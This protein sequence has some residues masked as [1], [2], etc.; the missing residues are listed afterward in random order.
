MGSE[1]RGW[2]VT[3]IA[4]GA[5]EVYEA[6]QWHFGLMQLWHK[7][8]LARRSVRDS[9]RQRAEWRIYVAGVNWRTCGC[10]SGV[11]FR[12]R[13]RRTFRDRCVLTLTPNITRYAVAKRGVSFFSKCGWSWQTNET[14]FGTVRFWI[15]LGIFWDFLSHKDWRYFKLRNGKF[16]GTLAGEVVFKKSQLRN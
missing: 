10:F 12:E 7:I 16:Y 15:L 5:Y 8:K 1:K 3:V 2:F 4:V 9:F 6:C 11:A 14:A 13:D